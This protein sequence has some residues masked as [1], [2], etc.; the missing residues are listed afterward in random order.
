MLQVLLSGGTVIDGTGGPLKTV[1]V[2]IAD[3]RLAVLPPGSEVEAASVVDATGQYIVPGFIDPHTHYDAQLLWDPYASPSN[4]HGVTTVIGGN[5]G[6]TLAPLAAEGADYLLN[7]MVVVE[8]MPKAALQEGVPWNWAS[9][10]DYLNRLEG[11]L[12]VNAAFMVGHC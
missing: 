8:G 11:R 12:G 5:C 7:M 1:D 6:F 3:G 10:A 4:L 9:F 2:G